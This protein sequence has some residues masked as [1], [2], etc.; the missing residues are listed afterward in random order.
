MVDAR[1][2]LS[3]TLLC[4]FEIIFITLLFTPW[5][6]AESV[7]YHFLLPTDRLLVL[8]T[9]EKEA[10]TNG[11]AQDNDYANVSLSCAGHKEQNAN[12]M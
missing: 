9:Q 3:R 11:T 12:K 2:S 8:P 7:K 6:L 5:P 10:C 1:H 4:P